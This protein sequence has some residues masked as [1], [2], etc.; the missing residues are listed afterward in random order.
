MKR[1]VGLL[2][3]LMLLVALLTACG[4]PKSNAGEVQ[5][6]DAGEGEAEAIEPLKWIISVGDTEDYY[7]AQFMKKWMDKVTEKSN[8]AII[9]EIYYGGQ[10][11]YGG[12]AYEALDMG[13]MHI[14]LDGVS[15]GGEVNDAFNIFGLPYLYDSKE[16]Q[17]NFWDKYFDEA[18]DYMAKESEI[19]VVGIVDGLNREATMNRP[20]NSI[21]DFK[22]VKMRVS[23]IGSFVDM[24]AVFGAK[25]IPI[26]FYEV[27]TAIQTGVVDGQENDI[28][29]SKSAGFF[30]VAPYLIMTDH[31][32]YEGGIFMDEKYY[33][34]LPEAVK[35]IM[36]ESS[37][38]IYGESKKYCETLEDD[39]LKELKEKGVTVMY[40]DQEPFKKA[41]KVL[42][43]NP[44]LKDYQYL[45]DLINK[46]K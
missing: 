13:N 10:I 29:L 3:V 32:P 41:S 9:G 27:F 31:N 2:I 45:L 40:P 18:T 25:P 7:M 37:L 30:E 20:I 39:I 4:S 12:D 6:A 24:W 44:K 21:E 5:P 1:K 28:A 22:N 35:K 42:Y 15:A 23:S 26:G 14:Y 19:R 33:Q 11:G 34:S 46:A 8:G 36:R 16:H 38:E 43:D 17:H